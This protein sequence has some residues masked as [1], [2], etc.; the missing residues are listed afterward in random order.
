MPVTRDENPVVI[1]DGECGLCQASVQFMLANDPT[2]KLRFAA[3]QSPVAQEMLIRYGFADAAPNSVVLV[4][5]GTACTKSTAVSRIARHLRFPWFL[6]GAFT[7]I[8]RF[9]R[10]AAYDWVAR[11][12]HRWTRKPA[13]CRL[14]TEQERKR[15]L[16]AV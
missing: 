4:E 3:R 2:G 1:Y 9:L 12:R 6:G 10:D 5:N 13:A 16:D 14:P 8:P 15:F 11:N 7:I